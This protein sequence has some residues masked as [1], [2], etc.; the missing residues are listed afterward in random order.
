[1]SNRVLRTIFQYEILPRNNDCTGCLIMAPQMPLNMVYLK[2]DMSRK[3]RNIAT[4]RPKRATD[5]QYSQVALYG[6]LCNKMEVMPVPMVTLNQDGV[7]LRTIRRQ[8]REYAYGPCFEVDAQ[9]GWLL[10]ACVGS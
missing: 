10:L 8:P 4:L 3:S 7:K 9:A 1:M 2:I 6:K 5:I